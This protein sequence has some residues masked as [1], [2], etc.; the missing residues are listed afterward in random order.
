M[1]PNLYNVVFLTI[2]TTF[3]HNCLNCQILVWSLK[4]LLFH[5]SH[6]FGS[7]PVIREA[8]FFFKYLTIYKSRCITVKNLLRFFSIVFAMV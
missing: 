3:L 1:P 7:W 5:K 6:I 4:T 8:R 2:Q